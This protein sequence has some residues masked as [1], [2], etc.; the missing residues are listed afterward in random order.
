MNTC[1]GASFTSRSPDVKMISMAASRDDVA[2]VAGVSPSTV[3]RAFNRPHLVTEE[4]RARVTDAARALG[5]SLNRQASMLRRNDSGQIL[6]VDGL[7]TRSNRGAWRNYSW[8]W[9]SIERALRVSVEES[10]LAIRRLSVSGPGALEKAISSEQWAGLALVNMTNHACRRLARESGL[11]HVSMAAHGVQ[12]EPN[13][14]MPDE[15]AGAAMLGRCLRQS[16]HRRPILVS[17]PVDDLPQRRQRHDGF[18]SELP[19]ASVLECSLKEVNHGDLGLALAEKMRECDAD[20]VFAH[21]S[22]MAARVLGVLLACGLQPGRDISLVSYDNAHWLSHLPVRLTTVDNQIDQVVSHA[23]GLLLGDISL[24][25]P[26]RR[27]LLKIKPKV[28]Q[29]DSVVDRR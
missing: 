20:A 6:V 14:V 29:G 8:M 7:L 12:E 13:L 16:G 5:Y 9:A 26:R 28:V 3:S 11:P 15:Y 24:G 10:P 21:S 1:S 19:L 25:Q 23:M 17:M 18:A 22:A 2:R 4:A 27:E